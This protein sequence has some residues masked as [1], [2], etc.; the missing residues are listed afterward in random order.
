MLASIIILSILVLA[1]AAIILVLIQERKEA[2]QDYQCVYDHL[3]Q[4]QYRL[5]RLSEA[6]KNGHNQ[7]R[8]MEEDGVVKV[9]VEPQ[10]NTCSNTPER[11]LYPLTLKCFRYGSNG[12]TFLKENRDFCLREAQEL[13]EKLEEPWKKL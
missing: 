4:A 13:I 7:F 5:R 11:V 1:L 2:G 6:L 9:I 12:T 8:I 3:M 10:L